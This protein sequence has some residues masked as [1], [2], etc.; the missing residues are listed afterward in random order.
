M[1]RHI[2]KHT[3]THTHTDTHRVIITRW[4]YCKANVPQDHRF[5][6]WWK[7]EYLFPSFWMKD[8]LLTLSWILLRQ[9]STC[10]P[11]PKVTTFH[12]KH[13]TNSTASHC[14]FFILL[15]KYI[16]KCEQSSSCCTT[17]L[18]HYVKVQYIITVYYCWIFLH[19]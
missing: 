11:L 2:I 18:I 6:C 4:A 16:F 19:W 9:D 3:S 8:I 13:S 5:H 17:H 14:K 12:W 10:F 1:R 15:L 7:K